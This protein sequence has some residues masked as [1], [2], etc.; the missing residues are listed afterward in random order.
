MKASLNLLRF[1]NVRYGS[2]GDP[3]PDGVDALVRMIGEQLGAVEEVIP[4]GDRFNDVL[5]VRVVSCRAHPEADRLH[6]CKI[7]DGGKT[8]GVDRDEN[9]YVQIVC[10]APNLYEGM[11]AAWLPPGATVPSTY[12]TADPFVLEKRPLRGVLSN[13][14]LASPREL[15]LGD[16]HVGILDIPPR[17]SEHIQPGTAFADAYHLR[18]D[19]VIDMENKMFTH[20]P[21]GF[22]W[23]GIAREL[24]GIQHRPYK[25]PEWYRIDP[26]IPEI[27]TDELRLEVRN[28]LPELVPRFSAV[29]LSN[30]KVKT[31][32]VWLQIDLARSGLRSINNIVDY[33][34]FFMMETGQPMHAYDYDKVK[35]LS[36]TGHAVIGIRHPR[37]GEKIKLLNGKEIEPRNEA[38][39]IT[40]GK[41]LIGMGGVMGGADTEVD[42]NTR[43]IIIESATFDMYSVRRTSMAHGL[44]TD[45]V[46]RFTKGQSPLQTLAA[47]GKIVSEIRSN[48]NGKVAS[49][50]VDDLHVLDE[51]MAR[52]S[53]HP[54]VAVMT[55]FVNARL[56]LSL[57]AE[58]MAQLLRNVEFTVGL[59]GDEL[60]IKAPF[61][62]TDIEIPEDV[63]EEIGRLYGYDQL[64]IDLPKR[65]ITP[66][67]RDPLLTLKASLRSILSK[68]GA[69]EVLT[70]SFVH[71]GLLEKT[72][73]DPDK[74]FQLSNALSPDLHYYRTSLTPSLLDKIHANS[75]AGYSE[76]A[77]FEIGKA[78]LK[79]EQDPDDQAVP[80]EAHTLSLVFA[81]AGKAAQN[82]AGAPFYQAKKYLNQILGESHHLSFE[83][84][85][86]ADLYNN[87]WLIQMT[88]PY[89]PRRSAV[90]RD[91]QGL[92]WGVVGEFK[93]SVRS[94]CKLPQHSAGFELDPLLLLK[95]PPAPVYQPLS[96]YPKA[97]QDICLEVA[98]GLTYQRLYDLVRDSLTQAK[99]V[100]SA[101]TLRP[102]DI[103]QK[104]AGKKRVTFRLSITSYEHTLTAEQVNHLLDTAADAA[105]H[106]VQAERI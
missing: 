63:V 3:A 40:T 97:E 5:I 92:V 47:L 53:V 85:E 35:A 79:G 88:A 41:Q 65:T 4:F 10:A 106:Q 16:N 84:L 37:Q 11:F 2:A 20:R 93:P 78:H 94:A 45:A 74:A 99:P 39:M 51:V 18:G 67:T 62:R 57:T 69:T 68:S 17:E 49:P 100:H 80:K 91:E 59:Q 31:S 77:L 9:G 30:V 103:Y 72:G 75:K 83:P 19:V 46:T 81:A 61:W 15:T 70:Y 21:D 96:K 87:P 82:Y 95:K 43:N 52:G 8:Q 44:F 58:A 29:V 34:N 98:D 7:D 102:L 76:F 104:D 50:L 71:R 1:I 42:E 101:F 60:T 24:E 64:R 66:V 48:D 33:T 36:D 13:G 38:I 89:E 73:Q 105:K 25:S 90:L 32:P 12:G 54:P 6:V 56:G 26:E 55:G 23:L 22:G 86:G 14:M 27:E 28:E